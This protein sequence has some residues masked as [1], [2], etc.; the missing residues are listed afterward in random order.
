MRFKMV[1]YGEGR[2]KTGSAFTSG[3]LL[4]R[5][6][7]HYHLCDLEWDKGKQWLHLEN[8]TWFAFSQI[9]YIYIYSSTTWTNQLLYPIKINFNFSYCSNDSVQYHIH[10]SSLNDEIFWIESYTWQYSPLRIYWNSPWVQARRSYGGFHLQISSL[11]YCYQPCCPSERKQ[12]V[13]GFQC[14]LK[15]HPGKRPVSHHL[16]RQC[17]RN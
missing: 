14:L 7:D 15:D 11:I 17:R 9:I 1:R 8:K 3:P 4:L 12:G 6:I 5:I 13:Y 10:S 2:E 16:F